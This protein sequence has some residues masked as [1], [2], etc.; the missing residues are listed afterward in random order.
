M[1]DEGFKRKLSGILSADSVGYNKCAT[2][3]YNKC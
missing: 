2:L 1:A 3:Q